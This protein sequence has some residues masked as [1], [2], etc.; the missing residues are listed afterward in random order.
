MAG[1]SDLAYRNY[2]RY[3]Y[4]RD[5]GHSDFVRKADKCDRHWAGEQW[6]EADLERLKRQRRPALTINMLLSRLGIMMGE[7]VQLRTDTVF[8]PKGR[9]A[10]VETANALTKL[11]MHIGEANDLEFV[12]SSVFDDGVIRSRGFFDVRIDFEDNIQGE[13]RISQLNSKNVLIDPD[14]QEYDPQEWNDVVVTK[15]MT[16]DDIGV[17]YSEEQAEILR[18][19]DASVFPYGFDSIETFRDRFSGDSVPWYYGGLYQESQLR[20]FVRVIDRQY[21]VR[22]KQ[23]FFVDPA[24][25]DMRGIPETWTRDR[26]AQVRAMLGLEVLEFVRKRIKWCVTADD[27]VL[28]ESWSPYSYFTVVPYF[29]YFR[30]GRTVGMVENLIGP[31]ELLNKTRSQ[32]LHVINTTA[33]SGWK[34]K[35]GSLVN[36]T[37]G[38]LEERGAETGLILE[39][40]DPAAAEKIQPNQIPTGLD[41]VGSQAEGYI[42]KLSVPDAMLGMDRADVPAKATLA[43]QKG[44]S[45]LLTKIFANLAQTDKML[46]LRVLDCVQKYYTEERVVRITKNR[47]TNEQEELTVNEMSAEGRI[48]ND[49]TLGEYGIIVGSQPDKDTFEQSQFEQAVQMR[50]ELGIPVPDEFIVE[51]STLASRASLAKAL[52]ERASSPEAQAEKELKQRDMMAEVS[53]KEAKGQSE[54]AEAKLRSSRAVKEAQVV[55]QGG[56]KLDPMAKYEVDKKYDFERWRAEQDFALREKELRMARAESIFKAAQEKKKSTPTKQ[57]GA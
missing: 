15:W 57:K 2:T 25:G 43:R 21:Y 12:R 54:A 39:L 55:A 52:K 26:I 28:H 32:E 38:E 14:A 3:E 53:L 18:G 45:K 4:M 56:E 34:V 29:P 40:S 51:N 27:L 46:A 33:N 23:K 13:V 8:Y 16:P 9:D 35:T 7:Q 5:S 48:V 37:M 41:R 22:G 20:R 17:L 42:E 6:D 50:S 30:H 47:L 44:G 19:R 24:T 31:Q 49:L 1:N 36:M 11:Y 10:T